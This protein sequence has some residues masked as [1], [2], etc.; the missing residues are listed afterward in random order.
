MACIFFRNALTSACDRFAAY[1][2]TCLQTIEV[3]IGEDNIHQMVFYTSEFSLSIYI[4]YTMCK[5]LLL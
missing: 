2:G 1:L 5:R 4:F 3:I